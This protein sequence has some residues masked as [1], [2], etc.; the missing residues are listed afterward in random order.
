[1][2]TAA[3]ITANLILNSK[4][5]QRGIK[6]AEDVTRTFGSKLERMQTYLENSAGK[7]TWLSGKIWQLRKALDGASTSSNPL[8][9]A[10]GN[11]QTASRRVGDAVNNLKQKFKDLDQRI[12]MSGI[13]MDK[14]GDKFLAAGKKMTM[15]IT[16]PII[17]FFALLIKKAMDADTELSKLAKGSVERLNT[18]LATLGEKFLPLFIQFIDWVTKLVDEFNALPPGTQA[19]IT[20]LI[21]LAAMVG[22][23][24]MFAGTLMKVFSFFSA[25]GVGG[26]A[27]AWIGSALIP[28][29]KLIG[30]TI[31]T[32][33][34]PAIVSLGT[35]IWTALAPLLPI[36]ALIAA[37]VLLVYLLWKNWD[38]L[39]VIV[40]Q[41]GAIVKWAFKSM[42]N[43]IKEQWNELNK[44]H[45]AFMT[46][47]GTK[48]GET[49]VKVITKFNE[50]QSKATA[51]WNNIGNAFS[52]V[53]GGIAN[54]A[55]SVFQSIVN[56]INWVIDAVKSLVDAL[57]NIVFP[58]ELIPGSPTPFEMGLRG[59]SK[60][61][62][63]LS[64]QS[65]PQLNRS[66]AAPEGVR[67]VGTGKT[68]NIVDNRRFAGG[69]DAKALR[70]ALDD[71]LNGLTRALES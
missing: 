62:D 40:K 14:V 7:T 11:I 71:Q 51:V 13:S 24:T 49:I 38:E 33:L 64:K 6:K 59:I 25:A 15:F 28:A 46:K 20:K 68:I 29:L 70:L 57:A 52:R 4:E 60:A 19:F 12:R 27:I 32:S 47:L 65:M 17:G 21:I 9:R 8:I 5:Y 53:F 22:P 35:A 26:Q 54:F 37:V 23:L 69:M 31:A 48:T 61:M 10:M 42:A 1:M 30:T 67:S 58:D 63:A 18:S 44:K 43:D 56:G 16:V 39:V 45:D 41:L 66:F 55:N 36:L 2:T 50:F 34:W 3:T